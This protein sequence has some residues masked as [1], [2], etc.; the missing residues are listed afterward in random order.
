[1]ETITDKKSTITLF[2]RM[3]S[4]LHHAI[5]QHNQHN[6]HLLLCIFTSKEQEPACYT[7]KSCT[8]VGDSLSLLLKCTT[9]LLWS[10]LTLSEDR[11]ILSLD[12]N[13]SAWRSSV[14]CLFFICP[15]MLDA[16]WSGVRENTT[17]RTLVF[18]KVEMN[19][20]HSLLSSFSCNALHF[21]SSDGKMLNVSILWNV[22]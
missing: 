5:F 11:G 20:T 9:H 22:W 19:G 7:Q 2:S 8:N 18:S 10:P 12:A 4:Q 16:I 1:M 13:F 21:W 3:N 14:T 6:H 17:M 15:S